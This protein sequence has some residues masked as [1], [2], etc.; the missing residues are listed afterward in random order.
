MFRGRR[1][2]AQGD[3]DGLIGCGIRLS[4]LLVREWSGGVA[5][6]VAEFGQRGSPERGEDPFAVT[7]A[8][9]G[10]RASRL[11]PSGA[12]QCWQ[13]LLANEVDIPCT[14]LDSESSG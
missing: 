12:D 9:P 1:R 13:P 7:C 4:W 8:D 2:N 6:D 11:V 14:D 5:V 3:I 10:I